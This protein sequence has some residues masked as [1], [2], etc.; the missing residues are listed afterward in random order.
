[1]PRECPT[2]LQVLVA[3]GLIFTGV[4]LVCRQRSGPS[5]PFVP[6]ADEA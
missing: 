4:A 6:R 3:T 1:M 2:G 5:A